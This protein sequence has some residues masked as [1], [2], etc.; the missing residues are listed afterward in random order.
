[1]PKL[2][3]NWREDAR[4]IAIVI[5]GV[6]IALLAQQLLQG[7]EGKEKV[8]ATEAA[9]KYELLWDDGPQIYQR[10]IMHPC[11]IE[12]LDAI[13]AAVESHASRDQIAALSDSYQIHQLTYDVAAQQAAMSSEVSSHIPQDILEPY[14]LAYA[15]MPDLGH[16]SAAEQEHIARLH[17]LSRTGG[18][19]SEAESMQM[20][21]AVEL[22]RNDN[23]F[24]FSGSRWS[25][26]QLRK[27]GQLDAK[28]VQTMTELARKNFGDCIKPLSANFPKG[29]PMD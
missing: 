21:N 10:A 20:L 24:M 19:L 25:L 18:G 4:E 7:R 29:T 28:R 23:R 12:R 15:I 5:I 1:M 9:M 3:Y 26:P 11:L 17:A 27:L 2:R 8:A 16:T 6:L 13:R 22:L 14:L